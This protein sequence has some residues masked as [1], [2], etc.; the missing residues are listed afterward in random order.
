MPGIQQPRAAYLLQLLSGGGD[1]YDK[2]YGEQSLCVKTVK[3][4]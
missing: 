4:N 3:K 1:R 2:L